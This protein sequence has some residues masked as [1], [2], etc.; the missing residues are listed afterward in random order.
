M[1][2]HSKAPKSHNPNKLARDRRIIYKKKNTH[3]EIIDQ[4]KIKDRRKNNN[5]WIENAH[6]SQYIRTNIWIKF[7]TAHTTF[8]RHILSSAIDSI[9]GTLIIQSRWSRLLSYGSCYRKRK[10]MKTTKNT[11]NQFEF[12]WNFTDLLTFA[13]YPVFTHF[14]W[15]SWENCAKHKYNKYNPTMGWTEWRLSVRV[16]QQVLCDVF[17]LS[18]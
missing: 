16:C 5:N 14:T 3:N 6:P 7:T 9:T 12:T 1:S 2:I 17:N 13:V 15:I 8:G 11:W 4:L 18:S 10:E